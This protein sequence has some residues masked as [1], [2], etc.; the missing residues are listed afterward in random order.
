M[1]SHGKQRHLK[2]LASPTAMG[3]SKKLHLWVKKPS[4]GAH[5]K[6]QCISISTLLTELLHLA[7]SARDAKKL[8]HSKDVLIDGKT[9]RS[10]SFP[11]GLMD[12]IS[13]PRLGK[14]YRLICLKG[15]LKPIE[16]TESQAKSKLCKIVNKTVVKQGKI[17]LNLHD[18]RTT[19][20]E[21]EEDRFKP[22]D[23]VKMSVPKQAVESFLKLEKGALCYVY[24]GK[25]SG[26]IAVLS[27]IVEREGSKASDAMLSSEGK[28]L[29]TLKDYL[30]VVD[31]EFKV[32]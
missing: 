14:N 28:D 18:G 16:V 31:K 4:A 26:K 29:I 20:I 25:H 22:G 1:A 21:K 19:I 8:L 27:K 30:F 7:P 15:I 17:Q 10:L 6:N 3:L 2:R 12:V 23:T 11:V 32:Q 5:P 13:V 9:V 24:K